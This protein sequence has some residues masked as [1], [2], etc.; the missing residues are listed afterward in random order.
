MCDENV[1]DRS[2]IYYHLSPNKI[3]GPGLGYIGLNCF[4]KGSHRNPEKTQ[5]VV[6]AVGCSPQNDSKT[7][8]LKATSTQ[9]TEHLEVD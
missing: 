5:A 1:G 8:M 9:L 2:P 6:K 7:F 4:S 3:S